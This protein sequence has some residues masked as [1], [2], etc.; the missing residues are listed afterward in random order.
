MTESAQV[1]FKPEGYGE[2]DSLVSEA[3]SNVDGKVDPSFLTEDNISLG[4]PKDEMSVDSVLSGI[5]FLG[6]LSHSDISESE[7]I[8]E[9]FYDVINNIPIDHK[10]IPLRSLTARSFF[11]SAKKLIDKAKSPGVSKEGY[12]QCLK[13]MSSLIA[14]SCKKESTGPNYPKTEGEKISRYLFKHI[15]NSKNGQYNETIGNYP[16]LASLM[17]KHVT[18]KGLLGGLIIS[19]GQMIYLENPEIVSTIL[20][21]TGEFVN[22][23]IFEVA[24]LRT[25]RKRAAE[26]ISKRKS[27]LKT[28]RKKAIQEEEIRYS[29]AIKDKDH[30]KDP[31]SSPNHK[32]V[33]QWEKHRG[34]E[35]TRLENKY[36]KKGDKK[37]G[38]VKKDLREWDDAHLNPA[39][40]WKIQKEAW[41][42]LCGEKRT[43]ENNIE[44][45]ETEYGDSI[46]LAMEEFRDVKQRTN[47]ERIGI[48]IDVSELM[49]AA[50]RTVRYAAK[51]FKAGKDDAKQI[52][53]MVLDI[54]KTAFDEGGR[55]KATEVMY[56]LCENIDVLLLK[57]I[58]YDDTWTDLCEKNMPEFTRRCSLLS[59]SS[60]LDGL[61]KQFLGIYN[62]LN[63]RPTTNVSGGIFKKYSS[64]A[65]KV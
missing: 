7:K 43:Y 64:E 3:L 18:S 39:E 53:Q 19:T 14:K 50:S 65:A 5:E 4:L 9:K 8:M 63:Y 16:I 33:E 59:A 6:G 48:S 21:E 30:I 54:Y 41:N 28:E 31:G 1:A 46:G 10:G 51:K 23:K 17:S 37:D 38:L 24:F 44:H 2:W 25:E 58:E 52:T 36:V 61:K 45:I 22:D 11:G 32:L 27:T 57:D 47:D 62:G 42:S 20:E 35:Q 49:I 60:S 29:F 13:D 26:K 12:V 34:T 55:E 15:L 40:K 56:T